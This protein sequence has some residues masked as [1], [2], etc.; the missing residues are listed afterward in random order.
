METEDAT[1]PSGEGNADVARFFSLIGA[2]SPTVGAVMTPE[3]RCHR[4]LYTCCMDTAAGVYHWRRE[5]ETEVRAVT[6]AECDL[7]GE[8]V[9]SR[10]T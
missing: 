7:H 6:F 1:A 2:V 10:K 5:E 9:T 4:T 3:G 8:T